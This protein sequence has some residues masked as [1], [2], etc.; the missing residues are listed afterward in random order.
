MSP[1][2]L[3][4][5]YFWDNVDAPAFSWRPFL[6]ARRAAGKPPLAW[7]DR[8]AEASAKRL[9]LF[10]AATGEFKVDLTKFAPEN[11]GEPLRA[12]LWLQDEPLYRA[13]TAA[14]SQEQLTAYRDEDGFSLA[15]WERWCGIT[16]RE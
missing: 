1:R 6:A 5:R 10:Q 13:M 4:D 8:L 2:E 9:A 15:D 12:V 14:A 7:E 16:R 11:L 3:F